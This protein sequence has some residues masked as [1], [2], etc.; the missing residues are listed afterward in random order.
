MYIYGNLYRRMSVSQAHIWIEEGID[1]AQ[2]GDVW[3]RFTMLSKS[4]TCVR[5][6]NPKR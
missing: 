2:G 3:R 5:T 4:K 1:L 6:M